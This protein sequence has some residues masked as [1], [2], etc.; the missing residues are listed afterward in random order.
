MDS[1]CTIRWKPKKTTDV[2]S[3]F[4]TANGECHR[5]IT[6]RFPVLYPN[7]TPALVNARNTPSPGTVSTVQRYW[8]S[9]FVYKRH[10][11][12]RWFL[13][14]KRPLSPS[15]SSKKDPKNLFFW[16]FAQFIRYI[17]SPTLSVTN[18]LGPL[19]PHYGT[20]KTICDTG[21]R[22]GSCVYT[23]TGNERHPGGPVSVR[24]AI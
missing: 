20:W 4:E 23:G 22:P 2:I 7:K 6:A 19:Q 11:I 10:A 13:I 1:V 15:L 16:F 14:W 8:S 24:A 9:N 18:A 17:F 3:N 5:W 21:L 12:Y